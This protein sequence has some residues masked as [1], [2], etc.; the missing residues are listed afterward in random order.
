VE[1]YYQYLR[2]FSQELGARIL[3]MYPPLQRPDDPLPYALKTL[4]RQPLPAQAL[5]IAGVA[6]HL[7]SARSAR[8]VGECGTGKTLMSLAVAHAIAHT[9]AS[10]KPYSAIGMCPPHLVFKWAR[11]VFETIPHARA[12]VIYDLRN[13]GDP[14]KPHGIVEVRLNNG[15]IVNQGVKTTLS[16]LRSMGRSGWRKLCHGPAYFIVSRE[17][18][19]LS[20]HWKHAYTVAESGQR[21]SHQSRHRLDHS[22]PRGRNVEPGRLR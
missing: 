17:T 15:K 20:Y 1:N 4:L 9:H 10:G 2:S 12:F 21:R 6:K 14:T 11:E 7:Q 22:W 8:I 13:G 18:G 3:E 5:T 19:K 16:E